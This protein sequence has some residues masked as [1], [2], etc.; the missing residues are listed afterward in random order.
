[1]SFQDEGGLTMRS[2]L[3]GELERLSLPACE[4]ILEKFE[5]YYSLLI[6]WNE[7]F[8]LT[9]I[10][11]RNEVYLKHFIDSVY[12]EKYIEKGSIV[13]DIGAGAG[14][15][16]IPLCIVREDIKIDTY[17]SLLKRVGFLR[18]VAEK[19]GLRNVTATHM[20][21]EDAALKSRNRY[22]AAVARAV[23]PLP[24]LVEYALPLLK[25]GGTL[26]AYKGSNYKEEISAAKNALRLLNGEVIA[27]EEVVLPS[28]DI[29]HSFVIIKKCRDTDKKYP[30][31]K[32]KP[33]LEPL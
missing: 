6:E 9:A 18:E 7:K 28:S 4:N 25:V 1:M 3:C 33:R 32:N 30:R 12:G 31:G 23:A 11:D 21:I 15:P 29:T 27:A 22:D 24:T 20:R 16:S 17:D 2:V 5:Q 13:V 19:L 26:V 14:F 8:N 10:T